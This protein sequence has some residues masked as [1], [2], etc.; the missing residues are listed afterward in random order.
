MGRVLRKIAP[1]AIASVVVAVGGLPVAAQTLNDQ[2]AARTQ[3]QGQDRLLVEAKELVYDNDKNTISAVG[4]VELYYQGRTLQADRVTYDRGTRR[5][6]ATGNA[7]LTETDGTVIQG[8]RFELTED[9]KDGFID[10]LR[11]QRTSV[12]EGRSVTTRFSSARAER[13]AGETMTFDRGTYTACEPCKDNPERPPLWQVKASR[14]IHNNT[15]RMVYYEDAR[16]EFWGVPVAYIPYFSTPDP[17]VRRKTGFLTPTYI[18]SSSLGTGAATPFFWALA[19]NYDLTITPTFLSRQGVMGQVEWRHRLINGSYNIRVAG[20]HQADP[21]AFLPAPLGARDKDIRGSIESA[22]RFFINDKWHYGWDIALLSD[23]WFLQNYRVRSESISSTYFKES[24]S[25]VYL[26]GKG[27]RGLFD[28]RGF[29]F[30][31]LSYS[32]WQKHQPLV[33]PVLDYNKRFQGPGT[34]GGEVELD[35]NMTS[36]T[37][38]AAQF[39]QIPQ[40]TNSLFIFPNGNGSAVGIYEGCVVYQ[41]GQ[42]IVRG[43]GG[44]TTRLSASVGWRRNFIDPLGQVWQPFASFRLDGFW[45]SPDVSR[46]Q[47]ANQIGFYDTDA[48]FVGRAMPAVGVTYR[49]PFVAHSANWGTHVFEPI[50]QIVARPNESQI[51]RLPNEDAQSLVFDD[52]S[53]FE[54]NKFSGYDRIEGGVRANIGIQYSVTT[55][56]GGYAN[57][58]FGQS[59]QLAGRNSFSKGDLANTGLDSGLET[60][61]SDYVARAHYA[62]NQRLSFTS[63]GR[64]DEENFDLRRLELQTTF[65]L[66]PVTSSV[67]YARYAAQPNLGFNRRKEGVLASAT[68]NITNNWYVTGSVLVDLDK[69]LYERQLFIQNP[70]GSVYKGNKFDVSSMSLGAGYTDECTTFGVF[71]TSTYSSA[72]TG[73]KERQQAVM[74]RLELRT[75]GEASYRQNFG[76]AQSTQDGISQ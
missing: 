20:I 11:V 21:S 10:S 55:D 47:N 19:P 5:V 16:I 61:R 51:G 65:R 41:K 28:L 38:D 68:Y 60:R 58:L 48:G 62:P 18:A 46:Y 14:I 40:Q 24:T 72:V 37:R 29:Y 66:G 26:T 17:T 52:T 57:L 56:S 32:D 27:D 36:L 50:A 1:V 34:I 4:D 43:I 53:I 8:D 23:K 42:C 15:E 30:Q 31:P 3:G 13:N 64:F 12:E 73:A 22:G 63:R 35:F 76:A 6:F 44:S 54:W 75:L 2:L 59:Y 33:H 9:F 39:Q 69:Y 70:T 74:L 25:T 45:M 49:F 71:Y 67:M 7:K